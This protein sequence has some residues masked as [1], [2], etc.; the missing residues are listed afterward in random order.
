MILTGADEYVARWVTQRL[1]ITFE[2]FSALG[3]MLD[4]KIVA[5]VVYHNYIPDYKNIEVSMAADTPKWATKDH[6]HTLLDYPFSQLGCNRITT[7]TSVSNKRALKFNFGIGFKQEGLI[8]KGLGNEDM[9]VCGLLKEEAILW[10]N[11][12]QKSACCA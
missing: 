9:I 3:V 6:L 12:G 11:N 2:K 8:R 5:G 1:G 10:R 4:K 7:L